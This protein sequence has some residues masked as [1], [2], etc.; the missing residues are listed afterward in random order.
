[1]QC[2]SQ[3]VGDSMVCIIVRPLYFMLQTEI[4]SKIV[5]SK[6]YKHF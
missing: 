1:M 3:K 4:A 6:T 5:D 2:N